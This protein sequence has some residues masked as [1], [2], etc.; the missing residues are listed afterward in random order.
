MNAMIH[1]SVQLGELVATV[2]DEAALYSDNPTEVSRLAT[3]AVTRMLGWARS[4]PAPRR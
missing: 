2:Y 4:L 3:E 1:R